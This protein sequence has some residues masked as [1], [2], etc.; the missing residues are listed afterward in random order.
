MLVLYADGVE[1][2]EVASLHAKATKFLH[3]C[4]LEVFRACG[5]LYRD[6]SPLMT[7]GL[8]WQGLCLLGPNRASEPGSIARSACRGASGF[9]R[10]DGGAGARPGAPQCGQLGQL[11]AHTGLKRGGAASRN[12]SV[13]W[14]RVNGQW[15]STEGSCVVGRVQKIRGFNGQNTSATRGPPRS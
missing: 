13:S 8:S 7:S 15:L 9:S 10:P 1:L 3:M 5:I 14:E 11:Q 2:A 12:R 4:T 6:Q